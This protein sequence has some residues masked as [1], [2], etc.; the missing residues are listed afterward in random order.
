MSRAA[1]V[2]RRLPLLCGLAVALVTG[3]ACG[4]V[5]LLAPVEPDPAEP[6]TTERQPVDGTTS[7]EEFEQD[8]TGA[9]QLAEVFWSEQFH[10]AGLRF[11][12]ITAVIP[13]TRDGE[14]SCGELL[15]TRN[16][17]FYCRV[18]DAIAYD[19]RWAYQAFQQIGD[20]FV[21]FLLGHEYAH[22]VQAR[23]GIRHDFTIESELQAD[24]LAGAYIGDSVRA[25]R[26][27]LDSGDLAEFEAGLR[28]VAD[29][30]GQPW[31]A[32]DAHGS[33]E[34]RTRAFFAGFDRS[35]AACGVR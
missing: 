20:A 29:D 9:V 25:Q 6:I 35:L 11:E 7:L 10:A 8:V 4:L 24:C 21:Y 16:N 30:P 15:V 5:P 2:F 18:T 34:Q 32:E 12:S 27:M 33:A 26:L 13:Y 28:A 31:F 17:A 14:V 22:A 19:V 23:L 1:A 3:V